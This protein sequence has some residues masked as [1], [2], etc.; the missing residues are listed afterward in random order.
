MHGARQQ[1]TVPSGAVRR[2]SLALAV[3]VLAGCNESDDLVT[4]EP[5]F[6][7]SNLQVDGLGLFGAG[8]LWVVPVLEGGAGGRDL[9]A[10]GDADDAVL[11]ALHAGERRLENLGLAAAGFPPVACPVCT[12]AGD[13]VA[14]PHTHAAD[15]LPPPFP[16]VRDGR[17]LLFVSEAMQGGRD[18]NG[19]EDALDTILY[20]FDGEI[21]TSTGLAVAAFGSEGFALGD[22]LAAFVVDER[23]HQADLDGDG[24]LTGTVLHVVDLASGAVRN[25]GIEALP[26]LRVAG[27][28]V[29]FFTSESARTGDLNG[30]GDTL[31]FSV[32]QV[33]DARTNVTV[34]AGIAAETSL[35]VPSGDLWLTVVSENAQGGADLNGDGALNDTVFHAFDAANG[36][37][38]NLGISTQRLLATRSPDGALFLLP[39]DEVSMG[40]DLNADGDRSDL[41]LFAYDAGRDLVQN[42]G[43]VTRGFAFDQ[44]FLECAVGIAVA[45]DGVDRNGDGDGEDLVY[46]TYDPA[47]NT[48]VPAGFDGAG[49]RGTGR[50]LLFVQ[51]E[52]LAGED[53]NG[54]GDLDDAFVGVWDSCA[55]TVA[56]DVWT[57]SGTLDVIEPAALIATQERAV[58]RDLNGDG[59]TLDAVLTLIDVVRRAT[60]NLAHGFA[61]ARLADRTTAVALVNEHVDGRDLNGDGDLDDNVLFVL[62]ASPVELDA[63]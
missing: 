20:L 25:V 47:T 28:H 6:D 55:D 32:L 37:V 38:R 11:H 35:L 18:L 52:L 34:N 13:G 36:V 4:I 41:V 44:A 49:F 63:R 57:G 16:A 14:T 3:L 30:D 48:A 17:A 23:D 5:P 1:P 24:D 62:T 10:D 40:R 39:V 51:V 26:P 22:R 58:N 9:N 29:G 59:D 46:H 50:Y 60:F 8:D 53:R 21:A 27:D 19:D 2:T 15:Q 56:F 54:D 31:D 45:E 61:Q 7:S 33:H 42:T 43:L 12:G